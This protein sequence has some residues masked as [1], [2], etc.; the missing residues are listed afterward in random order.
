MYRHANRAPE[1]RHANRAPEFQ[2]LNPFGQIPVLEDDDLV[3][4]ESVA[5]LEYLEEKFPRPRF[6]SADVRERATTR[7]FML[8]SGDYFSGSWEA[9]MAPVITPEK[10]VDPAARRKA[11]DDMQAHMDVAERRLEG[12]EWLIDDYSLADICYAPLVTVFDRVALGDL[13]DTRRGRRV[14]RA[15]ARPPRG[16]RHRATTR[17]GVVAA[18]ASSRRRH[19]VRRYVLG[20]TPNSARK[21]RM[22]FDRSAKP[23]SRAMSVIEARLAASRC[24]ASRRR[25]RSSH[26]CGV[27]PVTALNV[28]RK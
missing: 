11:R 6:L 12:R 23:T 8:W 9:W 27:T 14:G 3:I 1:F 5:I 16:S 22:K 10:P 21:L 17:S 2:R 28:R 26:W 15:L 20:E 18:V 24:A 13:I 25:A 7:Q 19:A 4:C